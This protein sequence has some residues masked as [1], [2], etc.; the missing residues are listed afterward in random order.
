MNDGL[1]NT[2]FMEQSSLVARR[3]DQIK[4]E[5]R[6]EIK[7]IARVTDYA[8][9]LNLV[10]QRFDELAGRP[11]KFTYVDADRDVISISNDCDLEEALDQVPLGQTLKIFI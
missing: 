10:L 8:K 7:K 4:I 9:F 3:S 1:T 2:Y 11:L 6:N 5:Y